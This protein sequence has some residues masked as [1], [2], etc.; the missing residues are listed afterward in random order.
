MVAMTMVAAM[1]SFMVTSR[2]AG[3]RFCCEGEIMKDMQER[4]YSSVPPSLIKH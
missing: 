4:S 1:E 3:Y 2:G